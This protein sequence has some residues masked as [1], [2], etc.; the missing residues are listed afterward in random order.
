M[1]ETTPKSRSEQSP[2]LATDERPR[3]D[4]NGGIGKLAAAGKTKRTERMSA[5]AGA[6]EFSGEIAHSGLPTTPPVLIVAPFVIYVKHILQVVKF[7]HFIYIFQHFFH[8]AIPV[9][10]G[11]LM[12]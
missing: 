2:R 3:L 9:I 4:R 10:I 7:D 8:F 5:P 12:Q 11:I 6:M 1:I